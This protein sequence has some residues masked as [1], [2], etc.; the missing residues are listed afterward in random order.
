MFFPK[1]TCAQSPLDRRLL[2]WR[3]LGAEVPNF[4]AIEPDLVDF[5]YP[6]LLSYSIDHFQIVFSAEDTWKWFVKCELNV[7]FKVYC[8]SEIKKHT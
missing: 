6:N 3:N 4:V 7:H 2:G 8:E 5:R 1:R